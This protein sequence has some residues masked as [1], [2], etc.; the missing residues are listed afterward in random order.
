MLSA[1]APAAAAICSPPHPRSRC[2]HRRPPRGRIKAKSWDL[3]GIDGVELLVD[4]EVVATD[5]G[6]AYSFT[7]DP[8]NHGPEFKVQLRAYDRGGNETTSSERTDRR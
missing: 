1:L 5:A 4:G 6:S 8:E 7:I 3:N 2:H